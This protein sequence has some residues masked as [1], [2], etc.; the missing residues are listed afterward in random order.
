MKPFWSHSARSPSITMPARA[1]GT[2][3]AEKFSRA[4][5]TPPTPVTIAATKTAAETAVRLCACMD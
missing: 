4:R 2:S 1:G 5:P 3:T